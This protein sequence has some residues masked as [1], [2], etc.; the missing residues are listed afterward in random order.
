MTKTSHGPLLD[1]YLAEVSRRLSHLSRAQREDVLAGLREHITELQTEGATAEEIIA[2]LGSPDEVAA[3]A[4][5]ELPPRA[6]RFFDAKRLVQ[7]V[8][9]ALAAGATWT[10]LFARVY[11]GWSNGE[12]SEGTGGEALT[13]QT[14]AEVNGWPLTLMVAAIPLA[15]T[16]IP[17]FVRGKARQTVTIVCAVLLAG[18]AVL[19]GFSVGALYVLPLVAAAC[20]CLVPPTRHDPRHA[21]AL[22][23]TGTGLIAL[24]LAWNNRQ[25]P[26][27]K[28]EGN[29]P[30]T[31]HEYFDPA[32]F[33]TAGIVAVLLAISLE[34][35]ARHKPSHG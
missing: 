7:L 11:E 9:V 29:P 13:Q 16:L 23:L 25:G 12:D 35:W 32:P 5:S 22:I 4:V 2:R 3:A 28:C 1:R 18:I 30:V 10:L 26:G 14:M 19:T 20:A 33:L 15:L 31:C 24:W 17:V 27:D 6:A 21:L 8:A 34:L